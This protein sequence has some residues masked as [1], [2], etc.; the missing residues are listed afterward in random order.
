[1][2]DPTLPSNLNTPATAARW[3]PTTGRIEASATEPFVGADGQ[4]NA[5]DKRDLARA[6]Q[7]M[8]K[9]TANPALLDDDRNGLRAGHT[10]L[11]RLGQMMGIAR[12]PSMH[13]QEAG[14]Q[15]Q[16][17][18]NLD[19]LAS[20]MRD[21]QQSMVVGETFGNKL[22][23]TMGRQAFSRNC[24]MIQNVRQGA[25]GRFRLRVKDVKA[26]QMTSSGNVR[27]A[28][29]RD[30]STLVNL[31]L[32]FYDPDQG[33]VLIENKELQMTD[34]ELLNEKYQDLL[35][36]VFRQED[37]RFKTLLDG[38][39]PAAN[40]TIQYASFSPA[41]FTQLRTSIM[42]HGLPVSKA[43][44]AMDLWDDLIAG[45]DFVSW[46][47]EPHKYQLIQQGQLGSI[48]DVSL[49]TDGYRHPALKVLERGEVYFLAPPQALGGLNQHGDLETH[50]ING[51]NQGKT[52]QGWLFASIIGMVIMVPRGVAR[53]IRVV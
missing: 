22:V 50:P 4:I 11:A 26:Y 47:S 40:P 43:I 9:T 21:P 48:L 6:I 10:V 33:R 45:P 2:W 36:Q 15:E 29:V 52:A 34:S 1:M 35:E 41:V 49:V 51:Y 5:T 20:A 8:A 12:D 16:V 39:S 19:M 14:A 13:T 31:A 25:E 37:L 3:N 38:V 53:G 7:A 44:M 30:R 28:E 24:L 46:W 18:A 42:E 17:A 23:E 27:P 32:R